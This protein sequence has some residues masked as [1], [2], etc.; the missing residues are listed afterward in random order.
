MVIK[1]TPDVGG[2]PTLFSIEMPNKDSLV[3][4]ILN[5]YDATHIFS[6]VR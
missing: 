4:S 3:M 6:R 5:G 1:V 2:E